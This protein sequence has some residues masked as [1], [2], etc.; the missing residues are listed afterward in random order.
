ML[1]SIMAVSVYILNNSRWGFIFLGNLSNNCYC[2]ADNSHSNRCKVISYSS[3]DVHLPKSYWDWAYFLISVG[4][5]HVF[6]GEVSVMS[7]QVLCP[8]LN[9][10]VCL[11]SYMS[12]LYI[13]DI[14]P[15]FELLFTNIFSHLIGC[16]FVL[17][18]VSFA[19]KKLFSLI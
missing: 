2:L 6:L 18:V 17:L 12:S 4:H 15:L 7:V 5:F 9:W 3:F 1:F 16:L 8:F 13:L 19:V 14:N 11:L 10:I